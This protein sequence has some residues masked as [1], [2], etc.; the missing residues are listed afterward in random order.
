MEVRRQGG[1]DMWT[2]VQRWLDEEEK[3]NGIAFP[4]GQ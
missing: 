3:T 1:L 2:R 4:P